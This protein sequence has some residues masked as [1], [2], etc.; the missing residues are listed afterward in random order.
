M[1]DQG[2]AFTSKVVEAIMLINNT[3]HCFTTAYHPQANPVERVNRVLKERLRAMCTNTQE[4]KDNL[5]K[6]VNAFNRSIHTSTEFA[7]FVVFFG[8][9]PM[10]PTK[11]MLLRG[12]DQRYQSCRKYVDEVMGRMAFV[13]DAVAQANHAAWKRAKE[14]YDKRFRVWKANGDRRAFEYQVGDKVWIAVPNKVREAE[15]G[16]N[17]GLQPR[18]RGPL[19]VISRIGD[20]YRVK[21]PTGGAL[22]MPY[23]ANLLRPYLANKKRKYARPIDDVDTSGIDW[24]APYEAAIERDR[25]VRAPRDTRSGKEEV[26]VVGSRMS[27]IVGHDG[28]PRKEWKM[29]Y[30]DGQTLWVDDSQIHSRKL[31]NDYRAMTGTGRQ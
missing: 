2:F 22:P 27:K 26:A 1:S 16:T 3:R 15:G 21:V 29:V 11:R 25:E 5:Q 28:R 12:D 18:W 4:W 13:N 31:V 23:H 20:V 30:S 9:E 19:Q 7:P 17:L 24:N 6:I 10:A 8:R 14:A